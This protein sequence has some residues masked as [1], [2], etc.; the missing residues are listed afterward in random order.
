MGR[1]KA[2]RPPAYLYRRG[3]AARLSV[4]WARDALNAGD[5]QNKVCAREAGHRRVSYKP[6]A[7]RLLKFPIPASSALTR[8]YI[9]RKH[10]A[11]PPN[12][13]SSLT[14]TPNNLLLSTCLAVERVARYVAFDV[15]RWSSSGLSDSCALVGSRKGRRQAPPQ[16]SPR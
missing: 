8:L 15:G 10:S 2:G 9:P 3:R 13:N 1:E 7:R 6:S 11:H 12:S 4:T 16:D 14:N 5:Q